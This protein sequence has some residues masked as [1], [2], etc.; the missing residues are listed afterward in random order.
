MFSVA[1]EESDN[2]D[3]CSN[4][5]S[6][7][8]RDDIEI[9]FQNDVYQDESAENA[10]GSQSSTNSDSSDEIESKEMENVSLGDISSPC[11]IDVLLQS[12]NVEQERINRKTNLSQYWKTIKY[13]KPELYVLSKVVLAVRTS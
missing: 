2:A 7:L 3:D 11:R 6:N 12:C 5:I 8:Q 10:Q 1:N 9:K 4:D 13:V